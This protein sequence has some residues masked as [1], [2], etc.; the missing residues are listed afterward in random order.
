MSTHDGLGVAYAILK[1]KVKSR[2][3][4]RSPSG[5]VVHERC[6]GDFG[7]HGTSESPCPGLCPQDSWDM[8]RY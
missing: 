7:G 4:Y 6:P 3:M 5:S 8:D 1:N 2:K